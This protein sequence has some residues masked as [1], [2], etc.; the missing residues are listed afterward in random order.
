MTGEPSREAAARRPY[1]LA[2]KF[3]GFYGGKVEITPRVPVY[4]L[5]DFAVWYSP[6][7]AEVSRAIHD[8]D[9][10]GFEYTNRWNTIAIV[11]DGSRVL[12]LGDIGATAS[13][14]VM[15]GKSL[16]FKYLGGVDA[17]P[18][19]IS[20]HDPDRFID[21]VKALE[22]GLGGINLEDISHPKCFSILESL[23]EE[24][25]IPVWHDDQQGT[26]AATVAGLINALELTDREIPETRITFVGA[27][28]ANLANARLAE[29]AGFPPSNFI[30]VDSKGILSSE[31]EDMDAMAGSNPWKREFALK[32]NPDLISGDTER[33]LEGSDVLIA[34][35][36]P[37]PGM[38]HKEWIRGMAP[39]PIVFSLAN[40][41][42]EIWP[43]EAS[44]AGARVVATGRSDF[45]NQ[46]N[47]SLVF[48]SVFR[49]VLDVR[50][51]TITD[52]MAVSAALELAAFAREKGLSDDNI[53]PS[54]ADWEVYPRVAVATAEEAIKEGVAKLKLGREELAEKCRRNIEQAR[55][56]LE[57]LMRSGSIPAPPDGKIY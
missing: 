24:M 34:A 19:P 2:L 18:I 14:P 36:V 4:R 13:L 33:A 45:A 8:R 1:D 27:G 9:E 21:V 28:A 16:L 43:W 11:T 46:V 17:F 50:A 25:R 37:G 31:R 38:I 5:E 57:V 3:A 7:V 35:S 54:M 48:P 44:D 47:N 42:P 55:G 40:P 22:P 30:M 53:I 6:G 12:G 23:R 10:L 51:S 56:K 29:A 15:E 26:A 52:R 39:D 41:V 32:T 49:G 20:A